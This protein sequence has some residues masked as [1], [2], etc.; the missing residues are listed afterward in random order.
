MASGDLN[1]Y[2]PGARVS[3]S[4]VADGDGNVPQRGQIVELVGETRD[5]VEVQTQGD[6]YA[7]GHVM[8]PPEEY[9]EGEEYEEGERV[10]DTTVLLRKYVDWFETDELDTLEPGDA[11]S[12][13]G[14]GGVAATGE[15]DEDFGV[16]WRTG[17][18]GD[19][20]S[21]KVAVVRQ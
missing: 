16:V 1:L 9:D 21:S 6:G 12:A 5:G 13:D 4:A 15:G 14:N 19:Y 17:K 18:H 8:R 2:T 20:T 11:V 7:L 3:V 10:G